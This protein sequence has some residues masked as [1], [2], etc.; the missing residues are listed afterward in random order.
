MPPFD[1]TRADHATAQ[2]V[3]GYFCSGCRRQSCTSAARSRLWFPESP[4]AKSQGL[5]DPSQPTNRSIFQPQDVRSF[6]LRVSMSTA[7]TPSLATGPASS[8]RR[9]SP[10]AASKPMTAGD[11]LLACPKKQDRPDPGAR[12]SQ[13][14]PRMSAGEMALAAT[15]LG[16][17]SPRSAA[18]WTMA[19]P[20]HTRKR[21]QA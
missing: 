2:H 18:I 7:T 10:R 12:Q 6:P 8:L 21:K 16:P 19:Q 20:P 3:P 15:R 14:S 11:K 17:T 4:T 13:H 9:F 5:A 1:A